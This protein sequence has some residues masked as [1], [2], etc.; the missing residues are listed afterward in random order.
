M[1]RRG[2][3]IRKRKDGRWEGRYQNGYT[4]QGNVKYRSVYAPTYTECKQKLLLAKETEQSPTNP[5]LTSFSEIM[6][7]WLERQQTRVKGATNAKYRYVVMSHLIPSLGS[8][9]SSQI[10]AQTLQAFLDQK[11]CC[12]G[13]KGQSAL[14][15]SYVKTMAIVLESIVDYGVQEGV[16]SPLKN[17]L[18]KPTVPKKEPRVLSEAEEKCLFREL[19]ANP[20][21][22]AIGIFLALYMG[23]RLGEVC[24]LRWADVDFENNILFVRHTVARV[25]SENSR[26]KTHQIIDAPKTASS[27]RKLPLLTTLKPLLLSIYHRRRSEF[28]VSDG[29]GFVSTRTFDYRYRKRLQKIGLFSVNFHALRHTFAT[30]CAQTGMDAKT[31]S[32]LLGHSTVTTT[33]NVYVHPSLETAK[34]LLDRL[35][36]TA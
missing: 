19:S 15:P 4:A 23:M 21:E 27:Y 16:L 36:R 9:S 1:S 28:V 10:N 29:Q 30:R 17:P 32:C 35:C 20:D 31:L 8:L 18:C 2:D 24:A 3:H 5:I 26:Q 14:S 33:L 12:G 25:P 11:L 6:V 7:Q 22:V 13:L 34:I